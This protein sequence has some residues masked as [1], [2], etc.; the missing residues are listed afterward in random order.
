MEGEDGNNP[1]KMLKGVT[2]KRVRQT[3]T[4]SSFSVPLFVVVI[5]RIFRVFLPPLWILWLPFCCF[6][7]F[8]FGISKFNLLAFK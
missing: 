7:E 2:V 5:F 4:K 3:S 1:G 6:F 8:S